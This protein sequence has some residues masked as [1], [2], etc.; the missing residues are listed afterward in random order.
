MRSQRSRFWARVVHR[1]GSAIS[2]ELGMW[3]IPRMCTRRR[4]NAA[5]QHRRRTCRLS[6]P[7][8]ANTPP[9]RR[10]H[11][12]PI[13]TDRSMCRTTGFAFRSCRRVPIRIRRESTRRARLRNTGS[14]R[15]MCPKADRCVVFCRTARTKLALVPRVSKVRLHHPVRTLRT[16]RPRIPP[17][18]RH[19]HRTREQH[20]RCLEHPVRPKRR[21]RPPPFHPIPRTQLPAT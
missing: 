15:S 1:Q 21:R 16:H 10:T 8:R 3:S 2:E 14:N 19:S 5:A 9:W 6:R 13:G 12:V 7:V 20:R 11:H 17:A 4:T 18:R